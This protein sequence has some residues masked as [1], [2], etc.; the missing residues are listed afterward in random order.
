MLFYFLFLKIQNC[1][2]RTIQNLLHHL[3]QD[4]IKVKRRAKIR[5]QYNQ[6]PHLTWDTIWESDK[7]TRKHNTQESQEVSPFRAGDHKAARKTQDSIIKTNMKQVKKW[8]NNNLPF[9]TSC[10]HESRGTLV[11]IAAFL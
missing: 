10:I 8:L 3:M 1:V 4:A 7:N 2:L 11:H 6:V 5:N 9:L